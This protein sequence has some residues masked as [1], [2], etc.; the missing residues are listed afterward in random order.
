[1]QTTLVRGLSLPTAPAPFLTKLRHWIRAKETVV[2][3]VTFNAYEKKRVLYAGA[4]HI[5]TFYVSHG[6]SKIS[7]GPD[8]RAVKERG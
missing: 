1:M 4:V 7:F 5:K 8:T 3:T 6:I 2:K